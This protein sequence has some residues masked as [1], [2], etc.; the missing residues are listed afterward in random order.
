MSLENGLFVVKHERS[1]TAA[2]WIIAFLIVVIIMQN[3]DAASAAE[4]KALIKGLESIVTQ[5]TQ[6]GDHPLR[7]GDE[8]Y[9]C[10]AVRTGV[11]M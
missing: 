2:V 5:C 7:I 9:M 4:D 6:Q 11:R 3:H 10:G 8:L 1:L